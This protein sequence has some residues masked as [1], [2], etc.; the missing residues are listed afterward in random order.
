[1]DFSVQKLFCVKTS[2][3]KGLLSVKASEWGGFSSTRL[4]RVKT[5]LCKS[6]YAC[7]MAQGLE[8]I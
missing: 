4:L 3:Y 8:I 1:M 5:S 7:P 6:Y 2:L